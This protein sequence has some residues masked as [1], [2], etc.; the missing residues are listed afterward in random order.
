MTQASDNASLFAQRPD[1]DWQGS[2]IRAAVHTYARARRL[3]PTNEPEL[4]A[5]L[6]FALLEITDRVDRH[7]RGELGRQLANWRDDLIAAG[8]DPSELKI[9]IHPDD[10]GR[11]S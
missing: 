8:A 1:A 9:P 10:L 5:I 4:A 2:Q 6:Y 7:D 11:R 3:D